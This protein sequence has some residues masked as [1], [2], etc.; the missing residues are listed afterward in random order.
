MGFKKRGS[1][2]WHGWGAYWYHKSWY[3]VHAPFGG[4]SVD[5][6]RKVTKPWL[7]RGRCLEWELRIPLI[8]NW[9]IHL[10]TPGKDYLTLVK[11]P[12]YLRNLSWILDEFDSSFNALATASLRYHLDW[13]V[14][15]NEDRRE[16]YEDIIERLN[17]PT[18]DFTD[19]ETAVLHPPDWKFGDDFESL[20]DGKGSRLKESSP[21]QK[22]VYAAYRQREDEHRERITQARHDFV[23]IMP[24]LWS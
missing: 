17:E 21:E 13:S 24:Y 12:K 5:D 3:Q 18:P 22:A 2:S 9:Q 7:S 10:E 14:C 6:H 20:P 16:K 1:F 4:V 19:E 11:G 8:R 23:D 15:D